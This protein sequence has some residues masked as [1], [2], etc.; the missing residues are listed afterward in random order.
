M[1]SS[2]DPKESALKRINRK[3]LQ[4]ELPLLKFPQ[5]S[6]SINCDTSRFTLLVSVA[7]LCPMAKPIGP[8]DLRR[9]PCFQ[10]SG[11]SSLVID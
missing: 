9:T 10:Q 4:G 6:T 8:H 2:L 3:L 1:P 11:L 7:S 5:D